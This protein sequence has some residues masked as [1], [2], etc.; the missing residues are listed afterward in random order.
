MPRDAIARKRG[1]D[2]TVPPFFLH[3]SKHINTTKRQI[4]DFHISLDLS[5]FSQ[6]LKT[7]SVLKIGRNSS[8]NSDAWESSSP[9]HKVE[10]SKFYCKCLFESFL[11]DQGSS[12]IVIK[13]PRNKKNHLQNKL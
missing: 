5:S 4:N 7:K 2:E 11:S 6:N 1:V 8:S 12:G 9:D 13:K 3:E 10:N